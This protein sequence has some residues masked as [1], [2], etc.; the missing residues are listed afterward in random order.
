MMIA[1]ILTVSS[2]ANWWEYARKTDTMR[3]MRYV[4]HWN[5][6]PH[7]QEI[8]DGP[9]VTIFDMSRMLPKLHRN[10]PQAVW[11]RVAAL[12]VKAPHTLLTYCHPEIQLLY[13]L[14]T[15]WSV[16]IGFKGQ[17]IAVTLR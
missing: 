3:H 4:A 14:R 5:L 16:M 9:V 1:L 15:E 10:T 13:H 8:I 12:L 11:L 2:T 7:R 6:L 17:C